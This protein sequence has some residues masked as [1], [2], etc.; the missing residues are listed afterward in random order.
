MV[1]IYGYM[2]NGEICCRWCGK[3]LTLKVFLMDMMRK[4]FF[5][6]IVPQEICPDTRIQD[7]LVFKKHNILKILTNIESYEYTQGYLD[8]D[9][10]RAFYMHKDYFNNFRLLQIVV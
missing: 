3:K 10:D 9:E 2:N 6:Y 5:K 7:I 4:D 1:L 8:I